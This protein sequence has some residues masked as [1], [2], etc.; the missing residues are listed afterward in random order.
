MNILTNLYILSSFARFLRFKLIGHSI[1]DQA[2]C[3]IG[4]LVHI[5]HLGHHITANGCRWWAA[6][7][8]PFGEI[9]AGSHRTTNSSNW[10][11]H[12]RCSKNRC[13]KTDILSGFSDTI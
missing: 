11:T 8:N 3:K 6:A 13:A 5:S 1:R 7:G 10:E 4:D 12:F 2:S 9:P